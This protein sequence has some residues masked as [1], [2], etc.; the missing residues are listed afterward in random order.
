MSAQVVMYGGVR[1][2]CGGGGGAGGVG[3][4]GLV[5][6]VWF[7]CPSTAVPPRPLPECHLAHHREEAAAEEQCV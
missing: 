7:P 5:R 4:G 2:C 3:G 1:G 6:G